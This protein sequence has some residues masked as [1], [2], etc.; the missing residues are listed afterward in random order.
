MTRVGLLEFGVDSPE[1]PNFLP[2]V[3]ESSLEKA[4]TAKMQARADDPQ[5]SKF[6]LLEFKVVTHARFQRILLYLGHCVL[7]LVSVRNYSYD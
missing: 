1:E 7:L 2:D 6:F 4:V 5:F 3:G